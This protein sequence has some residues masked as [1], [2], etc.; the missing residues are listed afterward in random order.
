MLQLLDEEN[1]LTK[2]LNNKLKIKDYKK[3]TKLII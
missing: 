1:D 2:N 3:L